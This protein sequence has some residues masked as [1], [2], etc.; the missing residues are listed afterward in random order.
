[1]RIEFH[2]PYDKISETLVNKLRKGILEFSHMNKDI[3]RAEVLLKADER[4]I[5]VKNKVCEIRL[6]VYGDDLFIHSRTESFEKSAKEAIKELKK[7][8][9]QQQKKQKDPPDEMISTVKV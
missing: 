7:M 8:V 4:V 1:M 9:M 6:T 2:T 5:S 3:S